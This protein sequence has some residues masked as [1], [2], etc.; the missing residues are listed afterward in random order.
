MAK[1]VNCPCGEVISA[2]TD[3][4]LVTLVQQ[5]GKDVHNQAPSRED[6]LAMAHPTD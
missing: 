5:H 3:D 4:E 2:E 6:V 1:A